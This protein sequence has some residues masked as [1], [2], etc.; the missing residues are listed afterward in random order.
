MK[1]DPLFRLASLWVV[2]RFE[3][4]IVVSMSMVQVGSVFICS[5]PDSSGFVY[6]IGSRLGDWLN[7]Y[8]TVDFIFDLCSLF[9]LKVCNLVVFLRRNFVSLSSCPYS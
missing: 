3:I 1:S 6:T 4:S 9:A 8:E 2:L 5:F 7:M